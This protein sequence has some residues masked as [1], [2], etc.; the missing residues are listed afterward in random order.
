MKMVSKK[1]K[2]TGERY[3]AMIRIFKHIRNEMQASGYSE[4]KDIQSFLIECLTWNVPNSC[5]NNNL[6]LKDLLNILDYLFRQLSNTNN[7]QEW[8]EV[9][10]LKYLFRPSQLWTQD[11][12]HLFYLRMYKI[13]FRRNKVMKHI[14]VRIITI[15]AILVYIVLCI[16][17]KRSYLFCC[18]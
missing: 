13:Y 1:I 14:Q 8:E 5:F 17:F 12:A 16:I 7:C 11:Q 9:N 4:A 10:G 6:Y 2:N 3:K 18:L 15:L